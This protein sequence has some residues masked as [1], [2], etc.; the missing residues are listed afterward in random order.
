MTITAEKTYCS[1]LF[2]RQLSMLKKS[3]KKGAA[4]AARAEKLISDIA[5]GDLSEEELLSKQTKHGELRLRNC[6]KFD[7]GSGYRLISLR[8]NSGL[9]FIF[10]GTHDDCDRWLDKR[11]G[12]EPTIKTEQ[13]HPVETDSEPASKPELPTELEQADA[14]YEAYIASKLDEETLRYLFSGFRGISQAAVKSS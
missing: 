4:A 12:D 11:R 3:D 14:E 8:K 2:T 10:I 7:L 13:L 1:S 6:R 5:S 9:C